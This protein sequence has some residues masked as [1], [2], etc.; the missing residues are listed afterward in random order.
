[1]IKYDQ[2][3]LTNPLKFDEEAVSKLKFRILV[4]VQS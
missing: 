4:T 2:D 3:M 1:M